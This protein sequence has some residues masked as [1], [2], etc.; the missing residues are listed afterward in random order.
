MATKKCATSLKEPAC[1]KYSTFRRWLEMT[2]ILFGG[3]HRAVPSR[4][5]AG[6]G[7]V[8]PGS[9][10]RGAR[11]GFR[12]RGIRPLDPMPAAGHTEGEDRRRGN[13]REGIPMGDCVKPVLRWKK[14][15]P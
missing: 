10:A 13:L 9:L 14:V 2:G 11:H 1:Q 7:N 5:T 4:G 3:M 6:H 15:H 12:S 8:H